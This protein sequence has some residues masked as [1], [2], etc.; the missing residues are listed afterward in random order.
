MGRPLSLLLLAAAAL[1]ALAGC[2]SAQRQKYAFDP[3]FS[4]GDPQFRRSLDNIG[5]VLVGGN[6]ATLLEN[7]DG[8][9]P[10]MLKDI[11]EARASVNLETYIYKPDEV[12]RQFADAMIEA[13]G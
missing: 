7:G 1:L 10:A 6:S 4:V 8:V 12:G 3:P 9:F 11:R 5:G 13:A 2:A